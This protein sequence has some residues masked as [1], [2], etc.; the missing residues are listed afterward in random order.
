MGQRELFLQIRE[1]LT[2]LLGVKVRLREL[3]VEISISAA[4]QL[5]RHKFFWFFK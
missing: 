1:Q 3:T 2:L 5:L 4:I